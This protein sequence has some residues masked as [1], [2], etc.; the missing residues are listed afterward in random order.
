MHNV[1]SYDSNEVVAVRA[2]IFEF[3]AMVMEKIYKDTQFLYH[4]K[5]C[6]LSREW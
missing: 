4:V 5:F 2:S 3:D 6:D 1:W